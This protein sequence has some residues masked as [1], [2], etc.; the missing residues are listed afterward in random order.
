MRDTKISH[1]ALYNRQLSAVVDGLG[2]HLLAVVLVCLL[3]SVALAMDELQL[4]DLD[5]PVRLNFAGFWEKD[6]RRSDIWEDEL[7]RVIRLRRA[8]VDRGQYSGSPLRSGPAV[9][10]GGLNL[11]RSR[12]RSASIIDVARLAE[13]I[14]RQAT[15]EIIQNRDEIR[16]RR[17]GDTDLVCGMGREIM[18]TFASEFGSEH[19]AW[20]RQ[21]L[22]FEITL[23][24]SLIITHRFAVSADETSLRMVTTIVSKR[25]D[26]F[27]LITVFSQY[28]ASGGNYN[29]ILTLSRGQVCQQ[30]GVP[31]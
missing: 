26:P 8:T 6:F 24:D 4:L 7:R 11:N 16:I 31:Q 25:S 5:S 15:I 30:L 2:R 13:Y 14:S 19:C 20:D 18:E 3:P 21:Q 12:G 1:L 10:L 23:P 29:C 22:V 27:N 9:T 28:A 17:E